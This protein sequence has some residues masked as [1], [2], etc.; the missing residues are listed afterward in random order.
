M[1][2]SCVA[3]AALTTTG[4][5][6]IVTLLPVTTDAKLVPVIVAV[7]PGVR[8]AGVTAV[9][10]G[11]GM[12]VTVTAAVPVF[13]S[14]TALMVSVPTATPVTTPVCDTVALLSLLLD[15]V[16]CRSVRTVPFAADSVAKSCRVTLGLTI[17]GLGVTAIE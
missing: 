4:T 8:R 10:V 17:T 15:H 2:V 13:P 3:V 14:L 7:I 1:T 5:P 11:S 16:T 9:T 6:L 12:S